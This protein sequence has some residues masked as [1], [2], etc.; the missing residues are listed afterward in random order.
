MEC[1]HALTVWTR[2]CQWVVGASEGRAAWRK[3]AAV[4]RLPGCEPRG[5]GARARSQNNRQSKSALRHAWRT[6]RLLASALH[7]SVSSLL[8]Q[9][10]APPARPRSRAHISAPLR[11]SSA[12]CRGG[13]REDAE[14]TSG[15][16]GVRNESA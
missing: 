3:A 11:R 8:S 2:F 4:M 7:S 12:I 15:E 9:Q 10:P 16:L 13:A 14:R 6:V 1:A 5:R